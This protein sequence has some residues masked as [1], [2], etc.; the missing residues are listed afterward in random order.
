MAL[1]IKVLLTTPFFAVSSEENPPV[2]LVRVVRSSQ[3]FANLLEARVQY[4]KVI[5]ALDQHGRIGRFLLTDLRS[6][7][8]RSDP[9][10]EALIRE[11]RPKLVRGYKRQGVLTKTAQGTLAVSRHAR[12][13]N[14]EIL[15]SDSEEQL[16]SFFRI[17][18]K[19]SR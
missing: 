6:A 4:E 8:G 18:A 10:W 15:I 11:L 12:E 3:P 9:G 16:L 13:D 5:L 2:S 17:A 19:L 14:Q 1:T 7:V